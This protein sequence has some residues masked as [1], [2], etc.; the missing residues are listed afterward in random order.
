MK[1]KLII[2][3]IDSKTMSSGTCGPKERRRGTLRCERAGK[4]VFGIGSGLE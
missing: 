2:F 1:G 3:C 4:E